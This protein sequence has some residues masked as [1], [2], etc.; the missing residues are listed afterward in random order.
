MSIP[1]ISLWTKPFIMP[2]RLATNL[3]FRNGAVRELFTTQAEQIQ[4]NH[5]VLS[6]TPGAMY[7]LSSVAGR[8]IVDPVRWVLLD[9]LRD[10]LDGELRTREVE[11]QDLLDST[12]G[13]ILGA[14]C[15]ALC[16]EGDAEII[17]LVEGSKGKSPDF[18]VI[19]RLPG[20]VR[21]YHLLECKGSVQDVNN[22]NARDEIDLCAQIRQ[23]RNDAEEQLRYFLTENAILKSGVTL[24]THKSSK[25]KSGGH[26]KPFKPWH[27]AAS[28]NA[29]VVCVPDGR[30]PT[31]STVTKRPKRACCQTAPQQCLSCITAP[32]GSAASANA[33]IALFTENVSQTPNLQNNLARFLASLRQANHAVWAED[34]QALN[35]AAQEAILATDEARDDPELQTAEV[36]LIVNVLEEAVRQDFNL[37]E[38]TVGLLFAPQTAE[39]QTRIEQIITT[40]RRR[41]DR[42]RRREE[43]RV[44]EVE[45]IGARLIDMPRQTKLIVRTG[46]Y[47]LG[48]MV[49]D[50]I[51]GTAHS[52][53]EAAIV[54]LITNLTKVRSNE[55]D[56][57]L[58]YEAFRQVVERLIET[59][60]RETY[61]R[62][63]ERF[64]GRS[65]PD[66]VAST[67]SWRPEE[68]TLIL[69]PGPTSA[70]NSFF[71]TPQQQATT[72][73]IQLG[74]SWDQY[75]Y[76]NGY[77]GLP[78]I[79]AWVAR[80]GRA[81]IIVRFPESTT[82][83]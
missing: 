2:L 63:R 73:T 28:I 78:G 57:A 21:R 74:H 47:S 56:G 35:S 55:E 79:T 9:S 24:S 81:E 8:R 13:E 1:R 45:E 65:G 66:Y 40:S 82:V 7:I 58:V 42:P 18:F 25:A 71:S 68:A 39:D 5:R 32:S 17:R 67:V 31:E 59:I 52:D 44:S 23:R 30:I 36:T 76:P 53:G 49:P 83:L 37:D 70:S 48:L 41:R 43:S 14:L 29:A 27:Y 75:P 54:R 15:T 12:F 34:E 80:D 69:Q 64:K 62:F 51:E 3:S 10:V 16:L 60:R 61:Q 22:I 6:I 20:G 72:S 46:F 19:E 26:K 4:D 33:I 11:H 77:Y 38:N 50:A